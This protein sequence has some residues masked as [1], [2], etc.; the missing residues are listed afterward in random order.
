MMKDIIIYLFILTMIQTMSFAKVSNNN[1]E[2]Y[3]QQHNFL[4]KQSKALKQYYKEDYAY[5]IYFNPF[6]NVNQAKT[7]EIENKEL[8]IRLGSGHVQIK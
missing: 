3:Y 2:V 4:Y 8:V 1:Y 7:I 6:G 5:D